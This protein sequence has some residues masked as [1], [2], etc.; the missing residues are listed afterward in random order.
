MSE[1]HMR[2]VCAATWPFGEPAAVEAEKQLRLSMS[3]VEALEKGLNVVELDP[4]SGPYFVGKGGLPNAVGR[5]TLDAAIMRG[6][7]CQLGSVAAFERCPRAISVARC[8]LEKSPHSMLVGTG[9]DNFA[10]AHGFE[11]EKISTEAS[12]AAFEEYCRKKATGA[13]M[14]SQPIKT[15]TLSAVALDCEGNVCAAVTTSGMSFKAEGRVGD[16]PVVG[17]GLYADA[18]AG[19][20]VATGD[21]DAIMRFCPSH[22]VVELMGQGMSPDEACNATISRVFWRMARSKQPMFEMALLAIDTKGNVGAGSSFGK[23]VDHVTGQQWEGFPY[24]VA[25]HGK[26]E[27]RVCGGL[28]EEALGA[29]GVTR[30]PWSGRAAPAGAVFPQA[31]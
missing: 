2:C 25:S 1:D 28:S 24:A 4:E 9:A 6:S 15:D 12:E 27:I 30:Q 3:S 18:E 7:D 29:H 19:A 20:C 23:W 17:S 22:R 31:Q 16:S 5:I 26:C 21:G 11:K 14:E 13:T 8:V 10:A